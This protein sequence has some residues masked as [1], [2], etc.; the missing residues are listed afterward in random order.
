L[1]QAARKAGET[2]FLSFSYLAIFAINRG[3]PRVG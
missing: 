2:G 3:Q 1:P